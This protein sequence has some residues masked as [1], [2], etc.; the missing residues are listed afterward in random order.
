M[1]TNTHTDHTESTDKPLASYGNVLRF[2]KLRLCPEFS[3]STLHSFLHKS[4]IVPRGVLQQICLKL[5]QCGYVWTL[6]S[7]SSLLW[8]PCIALHSKVT[9][10]KDIFNATPTVNDTVQPLIRDTPNE[11]LASSPGLLICLGT[12]LMKDTMQALYYYIKRT[13]FLVPSWWLSY[14]FNL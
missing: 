4:N 10:T 1:Y 13:S 5:I 12:R 9:L 6:S 3:P 2:R 7:Q 8:I 14:T 11:R